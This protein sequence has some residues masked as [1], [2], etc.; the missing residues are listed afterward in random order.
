[1]KK[2]F[3]AF[4]EIDTLRFRSVSVES[5]PITS[6]NKKLLKKAA[7]IQKKLSDDKKSVNAYIVYK[8]ADSIQKAL[9]LN[10]TVLLE[11]HIVVDT[12]GKKTH[13]DK[14]VN[15]RTL[16]V[17]NLP[18]NCDEE[19][20]RNFFDKHIQ[21]QK[22]RN[23]ITEKDTMVESV[24]LI[25]SKDTQKGKGIGYVVLKSAVYMPLALMVNKAKFGD[26]ELR[27][28]RYLSN[29]EAIEKQKERDAIR[30]GRKGKKGKKVITKERKV[31]PQ[32]AGAAR[33]VLEM[34]KKGGKE[35]VNKVPE[36]K[37]KKEKKE[38]KPVEK[39]E[40]PMENKEKPVEKA[41]GEKTAPKI[42]LS[43]MGHK[44]S[45][46]SSSRHSAKRLTKSKK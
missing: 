44:A 30:N 41:N 19:E 18:F 31:S 39:K 13:K 40:K 12:V 1:M 34:M 21:E 25:R 24:R 45:L 43:F 27:V 32:V 38:T 8:N 23:G 5:T 33:K 7:V 37:E 11:R 36:K 22:T 15:S 6:F 2:A 20:L 35:E 26:R 9:S 14:D 46:S 28:T 4:G 10:N 17:G 42:D 16:F 3:S 29:P